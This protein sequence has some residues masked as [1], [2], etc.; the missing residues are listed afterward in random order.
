MIEEIRADA[1]ERMGKSLDSLHGAF[2]RIRTGRAN[3]SLLDGIEVPYYGTDT[4]LN[5]VASVTVEDARTL[6]ISPWEKKLVPDIEKAILKS[7]LGLTPNSTSEL[8]RL[9]LPA[10]TEEN[11]RDLAKQ[12]RHEAENARIAIR[13][14]RRDAIGDIRELVKEKEIAEDEAHRAE[15]AIQKLTDKRIG[16]VDK[17]LE[18]KE[19]DLMAI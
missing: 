2:A 16:E 17:A 7:D 11:R 15:D 19:A 10:L 5:Q 14:I 18:A 8:I 6:V 9:P 13:N 4:P 3:P 12:A 1:D